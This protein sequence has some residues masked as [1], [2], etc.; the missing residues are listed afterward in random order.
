M[1]GWGSGSGSGRRE[2]GDLD[3][4]LGADEETQVQHAGPAEARVARGPTRK[5]VAHFRLVR[6]ATDVPRHDDGRGRVKGRS[7]AADLVSADGFWRS[8]WIAD[9]EHKRARLAREILETFGDEKG[10]RQRQS[11][12]H[13]GRVPFPDL[14]PPYQGSWGSSRCGR[15]GDEEQGDGGCDDARRHED[16]DYQYADT[17]GVFAVRVGYGRILERKG[18][19]GA[20]DLGECASYGCDASGK[21]YN[22]S[23]T[24]GSEWIELR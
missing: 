24:F 17:D 9:R 2:E 5:G 19:S 18:M 1:V 21:K 11:E 7:E 6:V 16:H 22:V 12:T 13:P 3:C 23:E 10:G 20:V 8:I 14:A 15:A 4:E